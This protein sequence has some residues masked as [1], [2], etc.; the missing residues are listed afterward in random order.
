MKRFL[1]GLGLVILNIIL[2][3]AISSLLLLLPIRK[4][5]AE[6]TIK[7]I[8][9]DF[10]IES[11]VN[12]N[13]DVKNEVKNLFKPI[14]DE[15]KEF[16]IDEEVVNKLINSK[17]VKELIG[18]ATGNLIESALTGKDK[19]IISDNDIEKLI[20]KAFENI[21]KN[22]EQKLSKTE[23]DKI[24]N[25]VKENIKMVQEA[26]PDNTLIEDNLNSNQKSNLKIVRFILSDKLLFYILG[27]II[28]AILG[29]LI[30]DFKKGKWIKD[31]AI[32]T[33]ISA[34]LSLI[35]TVIITLL[36]KILLKDARTI[37]NIA[38]RFL[39]FSLVLSIVILVIMILI[40][41]SYVILKKKKEP[42]EAID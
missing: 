21:N 19:K 18:T 30:L 12:N 6:D 33:L 10:D 15:A 16:G 38:K 1:K 40:L 22:S 26:I 31:I 4:V 35:S 28:I 3:V 42:K 27:I 7:D 25:A 36:S 13:D 8:I 37:M 9:L 29:I 34:S 32:T 20:N 41:I 39:N 2:F 14:Y 23:Q 17:E 11:A 5:V 24:L